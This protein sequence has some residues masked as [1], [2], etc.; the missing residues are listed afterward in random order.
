MLEKVIGCEED[1]IMTVERECQ[2]CI[3]YRFDDDENRGYC[4]HTYN[5]TD[6]DDECD[7]FEPD[8]IDY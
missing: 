8:D 7:D 2:Y 1:M 4:K 3:A 5:W 6:P